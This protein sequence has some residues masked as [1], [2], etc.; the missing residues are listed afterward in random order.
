MENTERTREGPSV[1]EA[2]QRDRSSKKVKVGDLHMTPVTGKDVL[3]G[4]QGFVSFRDKLTGI[5]NG[6]V[7]EDEGKDSMTVDSKGKDDDDLYTGSEK[8]ESDSSDEEEGRLS[9][10]EG[11]EV[12]LCPKLEFSQEEYDRWCQ[13]WRLTL[14]V[15][16]MGRSMGVSFMCNRL[17]K[18]WGRNA[19]VQIADLDN[20]VRPNFDP[21]DENEVTRIAVWLRIPNLPL[22]FYNARCLSRVGCLIGKTIKIDPTTSLTSRGKFARI[23]VEINLNN[24]LIPQVE[25][26]GKKYNVK[27]EGL[28]QICF[29]CGKY[30][31]MKGLCNILME[32]KAVAQAEALKQMEKEAEKVVSEATINGVN[33]LS[34]QSSEDVTAAGGDGVDT[35]NGNSGT[36]GPWMKA[37]RANRRRG[38]NQKSGTRRQSRDSNDVNGTKDLSG[39]H[40]DLVVHP[41]VIMKGKGIQ[42]NAFVKPTNEDVNSGSG[43]SVRVGPNNH[44]MG[45]SGG[46]KAHWKQ[47][48][49]AAP[50]VSFNKPILARH[51]IENH[52]VLDRNRNTSSTNNV[53][54]GNVMRLENTEPPDS[55]PLRDFMDLEEQSDVV[56]ED[57]AMHMDVV[58]KGPSSCSNSFPGLIKDLKRRHHLDFLAILEPRQSGTNDLKIIRKLGFDKYEL[59]EATGF[60]GGI[61]CLW[62]SSKIQIEIIMKHSQF[63]HLL[64]R[65][66]NTHWF[67]TVVYGSPHYNARR[68]LWDHLKLLQLQI[69]LPWVLAGDF[70]AFMFSHEKLGG[71]LNGSKA[72][73]GFQD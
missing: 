27:Y 55:V 18:L 15:R 6:R 39:P 21:F 24:K 13:P 46:I 41:N 69:S 26:K 67:L 64:V 4:E 20:E 25:I 44:H 61:W 22:E 30:G 52:Q 54:P 14:L 63:M 9:D 57:A 50:S 16:L 28:H 49:K 58:A 31:H 72:D 2:D 33:A 65:D 12:N 5:S 11:E 66:G 53:G 37:R 59:V 38:G 7:L 51:N 42:S 68:E 8:S 71:S 70:N 43:P 73:P 10:K 32:K 62:N 29:H 47:N 56:V 23:F 19:G 60:A 17:E 45:S 34:E 48:L 36:F 40:Q 1:E 3:M 35:E